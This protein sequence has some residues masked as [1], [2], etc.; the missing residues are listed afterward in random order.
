MQYIILLLFTIV[1][2]NSIYT[3]TNSQLNTIEITED[4]TTHLIFPTNITYVDLG[5]SEYFITDYT[6]NILRIKGRQ[7]QPTNL[8]V[9]T[10]DQFYYSFLVKYSTQPQL[11]YFI[12]TAQSLK[13]LDNHQMTLKSHNH[14]PNSFQKGNY[15]H[16]VK[17]VKSERLVANNRNNDFKNSTVIS[18]NDRIS[19]TAQQLLDKKSMYHLLT[20]KHGDIKLKVT[21]I[22]HSLQHCYIKYEIQNNGAIPY[23]VS[24]TEFGVREKQRPKRTAI[25]ESILTPLMILNGDRK[26]VLPYRINRYVAVFEKLAVPR[27]RIC[28]ME[29]IEAGRNL[30]LNIPFQRIKVEAVRE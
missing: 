30:H 23:D 6:D 11:N 20:D 9:I 26:R 29:V 15:S 24:Y 19:A 10:Q 21:G 4:Q 18:S 22:Y 13:N 16:K 3:Q 28:Y 2:S 25:N 8:T 1:T 12:E 7:H 27:D 14:T 5:N 17:M